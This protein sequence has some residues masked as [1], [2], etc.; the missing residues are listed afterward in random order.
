VH[1]IDNDA[2]ASTGKDTYN[3]MNGRLILVPT[4]TRDNYD[5]NYVFPGIVQ[6]YIKMNVEK[7]TIGAARQKLFKM[8]KG[9]LIKLAD[10][11]LGLSN[12]VYRK[13]WQNLIDKIFEVPSLAEMSAVMAHSVVSAEASY[14]N[15]QKYTPA[16]KLEVLEKLKAQ[17]AA[18]A[19]P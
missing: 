16:E 9:Q 3:W 1:L 18:S 15:N 12:R 19:R 10:G 5:Y 6:K 14:L 4:K 11:A 8:N 7:R 2:Q 17:L 13:M